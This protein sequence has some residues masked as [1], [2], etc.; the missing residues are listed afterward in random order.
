MITR[1]VAA[2]KSAI[3]QHWNS[4]PAG[5]AAIQ[6]IS[7]IEEQVEPALEW[8]LPDILGLLGPSATLQEA[9]PALAILTQSEYAVFNSCAVFV[10]ENNYRHR[11]SSE[12][13]HRVQIEDAVAH[14]VTGALVARASEHVIPVFELIPSILGSVQ[15]HSN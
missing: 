1:N 10:D 14:P 4:V 7:G 9:I 13:L 11:L 2:L 8:S 6:I 12:D 15:T 3:S 5:D